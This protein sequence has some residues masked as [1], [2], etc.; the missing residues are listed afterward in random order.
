M[1]P[2]LRRLPFHD[3]ESLSVEDFHWKLRFLNDGRLPGQ[4]VRFLDVLRGLVRGL[5]FL[6]PGSTTTLR[7]DLGP[8]ALSGV[9]VQT[10]AAFMLPVAGEPAATPTQLAGQI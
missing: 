9:N 10:Q 5:T 8:G 1:S 4:Q 7:A 6:P 3:P 2:Q